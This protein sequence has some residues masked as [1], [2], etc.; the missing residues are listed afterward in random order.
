[1]EQ[2]SFSR[3][4]REPE[5]TRHAIEAQQLHGHTI[6]QNTVN[7]NSRFPT[8]ASLK[9]TA[10]SYIYIHVFCGWYTLGHKPNQP[11]I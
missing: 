3:S 5:G 1:M 9:S 2:V 8:H 6:D 7:S 4:K 10:Q 11:Q